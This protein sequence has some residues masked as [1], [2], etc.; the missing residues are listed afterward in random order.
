MYSTSSYRYLI[1]H[2]MYYLLFELYQLT[3]TQLLYLGTMIK[4]RG[5]PTISALLSATPIIGLNQ[6]YGVATL[7]GEASGESEST[8]W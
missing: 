1:R 8:K 3:I 4:T 5:V 2:Y 6:H 7:V